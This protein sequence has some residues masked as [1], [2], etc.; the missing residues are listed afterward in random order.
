MTCHP[1]DC[2]QHR[3]QLH[4][5]S[6]LAPCREFRDAARVMGNTTLFQQMEAASS[7][8]KRDGELRW[9]PGAADGR[10]GGRAAHCE[11]PS[12]WLSALPVS[13]PPI[14]ASAVVFCGSLY[15]GSMNPG[16]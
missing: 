16:L 12:C 4:L 11:C 2:P 13:L 9:G 7:A 10:G 5:P 8:I 14:A 6:P 15:L 3:T 1:N